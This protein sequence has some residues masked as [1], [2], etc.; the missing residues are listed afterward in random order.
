VGFLL[1]AVTGAIVIAFVTSNQ[2]AFGGLY[3][4][5]LIRVIK[6]DTRVL[7][8]VTSGDMEGAKQLLH[9]N[10]SGNVHLLESLTNIFHLSE[11]QLT[12][13]HEARRLSGEEPQ[14]TPPGLKGHER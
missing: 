14:S 10:I 1:G 11:T 6:H 4:V 7:A 2:R 12:T 8:A 13:L 9:V 3:P 5:L